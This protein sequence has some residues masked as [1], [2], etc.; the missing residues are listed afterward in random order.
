MVERQVCILLYYMH[1]TYCSVVYCIGLCCIV[2]NCLHY[3]TDGAGF[4]WRR[5]LSSAT[6]GD[7]EE[8]E[9]KKEDKWRRKMHKK[10]KGM[11][12]FI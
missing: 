3:Y 11:Y 8:D 7:E 12:T 2:T 10:S 9:I 1:S 5:V 4:R 6:R